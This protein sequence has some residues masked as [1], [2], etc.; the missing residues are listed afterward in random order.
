MRV[1]Q[2]SLPEMQ[3]GISE[4]EALC[5]IHALFNTP[6][7]ISIGYNSLGFDDEFLRFGF[8]RNLLSPYTHQYA[9]QCGR[10]DLYPVAVLFYLFCHKIMVWPENAENKISLRLADMN[11]ANQLAAGRAHDALHDAETTLAL[12]RCFAKENI[13]WEYVQGYFEK[14]IDLAR[15][16]KI[17][18]DWAL[19]VRGRLGANLHFQCPVLPL[20]Q[21]WHYKNQTIWLRLD[22]ASFED[23]TPETIPDL[24]YSLRK[25]AGEPDF[26]LP[27]LQRFMTHIDDTRLALAEKNRIFLK[28]NLSFAKK[29]SAW[30]LDYKYPVFPEAD[31]EARLYL[32]GFR[33]VNEQ[34]F[35]T[36][37]HTALPAE[38]A[39]M[40][41]RLPKSTLKT[42]ATR[43]L[44]RHFPEV[45]TAS[46]E[47][48]FRQWLNTI[49]SEHPPFDHQGKKRLTRK[50]ACEEIQTLL[51]QQAP[52]ETEWL[53]ELLKNFSSDAALH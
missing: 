31:A 12:A 23:L 47:E 2:I 44:A 1:H 8:Y 45:L 10:M 37:F 51:H 40:T 41:D 34:K 22:T 28:N 33:T 53:G 38:K 25:K 7:T 52:T 20:G 21:H 15:I 9:N 19:F 48:D 24:T 42:L 11:A 3:K 36:A 46:L 27:P 26:I 4:Y 49:N 5:K 30:H 29:I 50:T 14:D 39:Q 35:C 32:D 6:H 18:S 17:D 13:L 16:R 43:L